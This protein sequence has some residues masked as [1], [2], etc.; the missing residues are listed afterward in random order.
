MK[1]LSNPYENPAFSDRAKSAFSGSIVCVEHDLLDD[2]TEMAES[3]GTQAAA[4]K[5]LGFGPVYVHNVLH[6]KAN[7][8]TGLARKLGYRKIAVFVWEGRGEPS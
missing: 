2:L 3:M 1:R 7:V 8:G 4:A 6:G 5:H